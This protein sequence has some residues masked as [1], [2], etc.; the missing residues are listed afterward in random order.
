MYL[1]M[2]HVCVCVYKCAC[3]CVFVYMRERVYK[4]GC[5]I[6]MSIN[7]SIVSV[8]AVN[9]CVSVCVCMCVC[10]GKR[11]VCLYGV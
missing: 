9:I 3:M 4:T 1:C 8:E 7:Y 2:I 5:I 6:Y 11:E 10:E